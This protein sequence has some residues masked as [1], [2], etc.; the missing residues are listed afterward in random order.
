MQHLLLLFWQ[1]LVSSENELSLF[2]SFYK[3]DD[4][5]DFFLIIKSNFTDESHK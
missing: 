1:H 4:N 5:S 2:R 3:T